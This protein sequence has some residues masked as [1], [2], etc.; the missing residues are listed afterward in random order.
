MAA[1]YLVVK[2]CALDQELQESTCLWADHTHPLFCINF[3]YSK[4]I[5]Y[6]F[7]LNHKSCV[8][9]FATIQTLGAATKILNVHIKI[10][11]QNVWIQNEAQ[12]DKLEE[13]WK[14]L[15]LWFLKTC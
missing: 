14:G 12:I 8:T 15:Q 4:V 3:I 9:K 7:R 13:D 5:F 1:Q 6:Y 10:T 2:G 11:A